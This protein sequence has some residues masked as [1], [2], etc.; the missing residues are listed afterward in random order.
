[1]PAYT[2]H[3]YYIMANLINPSADFKSH[4]RL[5]CINYYSQ[6]KLSAGRLNNYHLEFHP[7]PIEVVFRGASVS[8]A[9]IEASTRCETGR[10]RLE[11][12]AINR[13]TRSD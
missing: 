11:Q 13:A 3:K 6:L 5:D 10:N 7:D 4:S 8:H 9:L 12:F 1:M 2:T